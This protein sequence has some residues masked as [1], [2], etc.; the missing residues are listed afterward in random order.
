MASG[1]SRLPTR[2][3]LYKNPH[4][5]QL[6]GPLPIMSFIEGALN[7]ARPRPVHPCYM[8]MSGEMAEQFNL[9]LKGTLTPDQATQTLQTELSNIVANC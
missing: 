6:V 2:K 5:A 9:S 8:E 4:L 7:R 1:A 3:E